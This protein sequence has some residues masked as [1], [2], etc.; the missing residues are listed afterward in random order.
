MG[1]RGGERGRKRK[2]RRGEIIGEGREWG[3]EE[4]KGGENGRGEEVT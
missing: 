3:E 2:G 4:E 1:G